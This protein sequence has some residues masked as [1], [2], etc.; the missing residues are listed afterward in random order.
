MTRAPAPSW[1]AKSCK[2]SITP[3]PSHVTGPMT[4]ARL[5]S[6]MIAAASLGRPPSCADSQLYGGY[7]AT[8]RTMLHTSIGMKGRTR[9]NDQ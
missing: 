8:V 6:V 2:P 5:M 3:Y 4:I 9:T 1:R 7:K